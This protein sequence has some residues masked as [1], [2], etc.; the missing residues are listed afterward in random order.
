MGAA[1][2]TFMHGNGKRRKVMMTA[3]TRGLWIALAVLGVCVFLSADVAVAGGEGWHTSV[4]KATAESKETGKP[5]LVDFTGSDWCKWC[6]RLKEEVFSKDV[7]KTWAK[8]NVVLLE[9]DFP[10]GGGQSEELKKQNKAMKRKY[11]IR[12][13]PTILFLDAE[14]EVIGRTGYMA[15]GP[16][17]WIANASEIVNRAVKL[18]TKLTEATAAATKNN[19]PLLVCLHKRSDKESAVRAKVLFKS[20]KMVDFAEKYL[21]VAYVLA[22]R[23]SGPATS[24]RKAIIAMIK[25]HEL[26]GD[27][28]H[29]LFLNVSSEKVLYKNT[30]TSKHDVEK[31]TAALLAAMPPIEYDGEWI[32]DYARAE[33]IAAQKKYPILLNFTGSNWCGWCVKLRKEIFS[34]D[35]FKSYAKDNVVLVKLDFPKKIKQSVALKR[36]NKA[37]LKK[38]RV[39]GFP[40]LIVLNAKAE[41]IGKMGYVRG[42][43]DPFIEKLKSIVEK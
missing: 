21:E 28:L 4:E 20:S 32:E 7:F 39:R 5:I 27:G 3:R 16:K 17:K 23:S 12:G 13:F 15:G 40:T 14:G 25:D 22:P 41:R 24:E 19:R 42:G 36:Q 37:L 43:P 34:T 6:V 26:A 2:E 31:L 8:D 9:L 11:S 30:Q 1:L 33:L 10:R 35:T 38:Y 18:H 29:L